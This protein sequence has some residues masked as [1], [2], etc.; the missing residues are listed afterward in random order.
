[1]AAG[2]PARGSRLPAGPWRSP[3]HTAW[4]AMRERLQAFPGALPLRPRTFAPR[5]NETPAFPP[6]RHHVEGGV[7]ARFRP[8]LQTMSVVLLESGRAIPTLLA[9]RVNAHCHLGR[10]FR[11]CCL[12]DHAAL[13]GGAQSGSSRLPTLLPQRPRSSTRRRA[14]RFP[15]VGAGGS[16]AGGAAPR[17]RQSVPCRPPSWWPRY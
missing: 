5:T 13:R 3:S 11:R 16:S 10:G 9:G 2:E 1:M 7:E 6:V 8:F 4:L 12:K 15:A 14:K 17:W